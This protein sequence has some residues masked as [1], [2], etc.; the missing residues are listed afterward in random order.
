[1]P[2]R[3]QISDAGCSWL[4]PGS[5][6]ASSVVHVCTR[7]FYRRAPLHTG[8]VFCAQ[9]VMLREEKSRL[10]DAAA[11]MRQREEQKAR[12]KAAI[13][14]LKSNIQHV[15]F[16]DK[17]QQ[18]RWWRACVCVC[19]P[20]R[21]CSRPRN[22]QRST[23]LARARGVVWCCLPQHGAR[24]VPEVHRRA[25]VSVRI[26]MNYFASLAKRRPLSDSVG[27]RCRAR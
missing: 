17:A 20:R 19:R 18:V 27:A 13:N 21:G 24:G 8:N 1:M 3:D 10:E 26:I 15:S 12:G 14:K 11:A 7:L 2:L 6:Q 9:H 22:Q 23:A 4:F 16:E 5:S 25:R